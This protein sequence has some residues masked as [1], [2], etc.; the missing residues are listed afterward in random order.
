MT[1]CRRISPHCRK[2][3]SSS[4]AKNPCTRDGH[5]GTKVKGFYSPKKSCN[6]I[7]KIQAAARGRIAR[8]KSKGSLKGLQRSFALG[9]IAAHIR[10]RRSSK[11]AKGAKGPRR[12]ERLKKN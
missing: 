1:K 7:T 3:K 10:K 2:I 4:K 8:S 6:A 11:G 5:S 9:K 12:S